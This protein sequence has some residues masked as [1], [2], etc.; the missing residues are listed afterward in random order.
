MPLEL[1]KILREELA[2]RT[3]FIDAGVEQTSPALALIILNLTRRAGQGDVWAKK[4]LLSYRRL[5]SE[6]EDR[7][8]EEERDKRSIEELN[9]VLGAWRQ[10]TYP[11]EGEK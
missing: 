9:K 6:E 10:K 8:A 5:N 2:R 7:R 11:C 1:R 3:R 4:L